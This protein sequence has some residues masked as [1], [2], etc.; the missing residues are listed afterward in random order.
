MIGPLLFAEDTMPFWVYI[1]QNELTGKLYKGQTSDLASRIKR[2][3]SHQAGSLRY[4]CKQKG[5]W[6]LIHSEEYATRSEAMKRERFLKSG[7]GRECLKANILK[8]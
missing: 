4:T 6:R 2:H 3:N 1:L 8:H 5:S 7:Q